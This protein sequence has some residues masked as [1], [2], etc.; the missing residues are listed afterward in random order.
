MKKVFSLVTLL[1]TTVH[2]DWGPVNFQISKHEDN[3]QPTITAPW[4]SWIG[5]IQKDEHMEPSKTHELIF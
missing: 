1:A 5:L 3:D 2:A 4:G